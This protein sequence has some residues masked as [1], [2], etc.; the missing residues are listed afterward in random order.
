MLLA[1]TTLIAA[2]AF[3]CYHS[4]KSKPSPP[5]PPPSSHKASAG[6]Q[7]H[8]F[9][10]KNRP[11]PPLP[12]VILADEKY[13][14]GQGY[15]YGHAASLAEV[16][17]LFPTVK[18]S[19]RGGGW[20]GEWVGRHARPNAQARLD[21]GGGVRSPIMTPPAFRQH[22]GVLVSFVRTPEKW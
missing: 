15:D 1:V 8:T 19:G 12:V 7:A 3:F 20:V 22:P 16:K 21:V 18:D 17:A 11:L 6:T 13:G 10:Y 9:E 2:V 14:Y 4:R 5:A